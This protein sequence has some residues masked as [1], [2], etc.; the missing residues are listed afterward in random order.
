MKTER[1]TIIDAVKGLA[2]VSIV[3]AH[4]ASVGTDVTYLTRIF[5]RL[6]G[7][8]GTFGVPIFFLCAGYL[9]K[10][11]RITKED[12]LK[13]FKRI[14]VPWFIVGTVVYL[15]VAIRKDTVSYFDFIS[16][17]ESYL[18]YLA[19]YVVFYLYSVVCKSWKI[20]VLCLLASFIFRIWI[21]ITGTHDLNLNIIPLFWAFW[22]CIG[23]IL[24][25]NRFDKLVLKNNIAKWTVFVGWVVSLACAIIFKFGLNYWSLGATFLEALATICLI[26]IAKQ[27][28]E[29]RLLQ[30]MGRNSLAIYLCHMPI[31]GIVVHFTMPG[32]VVV[33]FRGIVVLLIT[34][35]AL[36]SYSHIVKKKINN[37]FFLWGIGLECAKKH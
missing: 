28:K 25:N 23:K 34:N 16:G 2:T 21:E 10:D 18:Y 8:L 1:D 22:F 20:D 31:A 26:T 14:I 15:Y 9:V 11:Q 24:R 4:T 36:F 29:S 7:V 12:L 13:K 37:E 30:W 32:G 19:M 5:S 27:Y 33:L 35:I 6:I 3:F 17:K